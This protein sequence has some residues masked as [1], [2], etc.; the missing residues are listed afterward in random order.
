MS[1]ALVFCSTLSAHLSTPL[2]S[3]TPL[4]FQVIMSNTNR[5]FFRSANPPSTVKN[6][7]DISMHTLRSICE[8]SVSPFAPST[9]PSSIPEPPQRPRPTSLSLFQF[10]ECGEQV[11]HLQRNQ[12][13]F[14]TSKQG[15]VNGESMFQWS[16]SPRIRSRLLGRCMKRCSTI[17]TR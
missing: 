17:T 1:Q 13:L 6:Y 10:E 3:P 2:H 9:T 16:F 11:L 5:T 12:C 15:N 14:V 8:Q 4:H 7:S